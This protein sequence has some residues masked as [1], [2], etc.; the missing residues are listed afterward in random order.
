[1]VSPDN[2]EKFEDMSDEQLA[3]LMHAAGIAPGLTAEQL[4]RAC[5]D[6]GGPPE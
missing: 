5:E 4:Q 1:M 3:R 2:Q 6:M